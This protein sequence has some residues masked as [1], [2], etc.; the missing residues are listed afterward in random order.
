MLKTTRNQAAFSVL[1][2]QFR[3][4][5]AEHWRDALARRITPGLLASLIADAVRRT[6]AAGCEDMAEQFAVLGEALADESDD[7]A[8]DD[9]DMNMADLYDWAD[10]ARVLIERG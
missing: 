7:A 6:G 8:Y 1:R 2:W 4:N 10:A 9:F 5:I 3:I